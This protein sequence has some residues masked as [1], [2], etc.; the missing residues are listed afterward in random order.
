MTCP[1]NHDAIKSSP[2]WSLLEPVGVQ[3]ALRPGRPDLELRNCACGSTLG[4][5]VTKE[6]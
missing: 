3:R 4:K 6:S 5:P 1:I 2:A